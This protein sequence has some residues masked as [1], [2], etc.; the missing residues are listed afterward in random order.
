MVGQQALPQVQRLGAC[1]EFTRGAAAAATRALC[2]LAAGD[3]SGPCLAAASA[4][5]NLCRAET[6]HLVATPEALRAVVGALE[7][8]GWR[9]PQWA[10]QASADA[11]FQT[12]L[13][14]VANLTD[15][16]ATTNKLVCAQLVTMT[17]GM[18]ASLPLNDPVAFVSLHT[19]H[20]FACAASGLALVAERASTELCGALGTCLR[21]DSESVNHEEVLLTIHKLLT[22]S[23]HAQSVLASVLDADLLP[24]ALEL[25]DAHPE[26]AALVLSAAAAAAAETTS[27]IRVICPQTLHAAAALLRDGPPVAALRVSEAL[28]RLSQH[29]ASDAIV[30]RRL[31]ECGASAEF[32]GICA[33]SAAAALLLA[34]MKYCAA[35][36]TDAAS[37]RCSS[38]G[39]QRDVRLCARCKTS[40]YCR[41]SLLLSA[42]SAT[43]CNTNRCAPP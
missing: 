16:E 2:R 19:L 37:L 18:V 9:A 5:A 10:A 23:A 14:L 31:L 6:R 26:S 8:W 41:C 20:N 35:V 7:R 13:T 21:A 28:Q 32:A 39:A 38:C 36:E 24:P 15:E 27:L 30:G 40:A 25:Y 43:G 29:A 22:S 4:L 11:A 12:L 34:R 17:V 3:E 42:R 33:Q 1:A